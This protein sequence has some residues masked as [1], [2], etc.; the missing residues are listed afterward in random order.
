MKIRVVAKVQQ[1]YVTS[2][3]AIV[4]PAAGW[5]SCSTTCWCHCHCP[6]VDLTQVRDP[7]EL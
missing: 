4:A 7:D 6:A 2:P 5:C 1:K 3:W